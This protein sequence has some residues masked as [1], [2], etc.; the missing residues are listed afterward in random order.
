MYVG[1]SYCKT[2]YRHTDTK[3][4]KNLALAKRNA[5]SYCEE[6]VIKS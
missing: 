5:L 3:G 6:V 4:R 1:M 2:L